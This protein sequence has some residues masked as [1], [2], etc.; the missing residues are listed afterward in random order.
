MA[1]LTQET[2]LCLLR[3]RSNFD[4]KETLFF[5]FYDW[6]EVVTIGE[7]PPLSEPV[8]KSPRQRRKKYVFEGVG[9]R[10]RKNDPRILGGGGQNVAHLR[11]VSPECV[12]IL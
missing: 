7:F 5:A 1:G 6:R 11:V 12:G 2:L 9:G 3:Y 10:R 4:V 8:R